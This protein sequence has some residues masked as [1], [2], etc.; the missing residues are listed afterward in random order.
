MCHPLAACNSKIWTS[1]GEINTLNPGIGDLQL[2]RWLHQ[3]G[4]GL[5]S[6]PL[7]EE[8]TQIPWEQKNHLYTLSFEIVSESK[9]HSLF[10]LSL[11][12]ST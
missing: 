9:N 12:S 10:P 3:T 2:T 5:T 11:P 6:A 7:R 8:G 4:T 1:R